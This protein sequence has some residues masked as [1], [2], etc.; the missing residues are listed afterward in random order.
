MKGITAEIVEPYAEALMSLAKSKDLTDQF[1]VEIGA[2]LSI[3]A[4]SP[5]LNQ[6]LASPIYPIEK[7]Q[8]VVRQAFE[9]KVH[10]YLFNF[11]ML[12]VDRQ[13]IL[14]L[15]GIGEAYQAL[16][17]E[18]KQIVLAEVTS[19]IELTSEQQQQVIDRVKSMTKAQDVEL[20]MHID[21]DILGGVVI[22]VGSQVLDASL[23]GQLRSIR[24]SLSQG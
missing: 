10:P 19:A 5:D 15:Q 21:P 16:L 22:K 4:E 17:R 8:A 9:G 20:K 6:F 1:G 18:L 7:K 13:R 2:L 14:L 3:L 12:L 23:R 24:V 11:L